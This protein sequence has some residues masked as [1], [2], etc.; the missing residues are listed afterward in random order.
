MKTIFDVVF[1]A[2]N[3]AKVT[4]QQRK[5]HAASNSNY[6]LVTWKQYKTLARPSV[7]LHYMSVVCFSRSWWAASVIHISQAIYEVVLL[8]SP[9]LSSLLIKPPSTPADSFKWKSYWEAECPL[10]KGQPYLPGDIVKVNVFTNFGIVPNG[11]YIGG[12]EERNLSAFT[13]N[14]SKKNNKM[15]EGDLH[16]S[17]VAVFALIMQW[18]HRE[19]KLL[20]FFCICFI[21]P[22]IRLLRVELC[23]EFGRKRHFNGVVIQRGEFPFY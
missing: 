7:E 2:F 10:I 5:S 11:F 8:T 23:M 13:T 6:Q 9:K 3:T 22:D 4:T 16:S 12:E 14:N 17:T 15:P 20:F 1:T 19:H 21:T 18:S